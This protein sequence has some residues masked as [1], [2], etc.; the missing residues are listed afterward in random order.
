VAESKADEVAKPA[1]P[2]ER[3]TWRP[4]AGLIYFWQQET[5]PGEALS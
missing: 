1:N 3:S 5:S 4:L 2:N